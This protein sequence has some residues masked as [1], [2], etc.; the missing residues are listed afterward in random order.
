MSQPTIMSSTSPLKKIIHAMRA[1]ERGDYDPI[2]LQDFLQESGDLG[3]LAKMVDTM[4]STI[5]QRNVQLNLLNKV[6]PIGVSLSAEKDFNRLLESLVVEAQAF[7]NADA[8]SLYL[9]EED[10]LRFVILRNTSLNMHMGGTSGSPIAFK[11]IR[12]YNEDGSENRSNVV[13]HAALTH[14]RI[15]IADAYEAEGFDF[16]G[17]KSFDEQTRYRSKSFLTIPLENKDGKV[18]GVL[19]LIN[20]KDP[21]TGEIVAFEADLVLEALILLATAA[22]DGYIREAA[23]RSEIAKLRIEVDQSRRAKQVDEITETQF[24]RDL[25]TRAKEMRS[26]GKK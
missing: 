26:K 9:V 3:Q 12:M 20:A 13:S 10:K 15:M 21:K 19:Q 18:M 24:F 7:T 8:G 14:Q 11:P 2:L 16:S 22:L 4:A 17:T 1:I 6:I 5:S 23:L 25:T